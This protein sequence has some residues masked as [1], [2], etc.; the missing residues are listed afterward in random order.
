L[1]KI[2]FTTN[3]WPKKAEQTMTL[4]ALP[5]RKRLGTTNSLATVFG[6]TRI[7][8]DSMRLSRCLKI[9][10]R[11]TRRSPSIWGRT[12]MLTV[13]SLRRHDTLKRRKDES[14]LDCRDRLKPNGGMRRRKKKKWTKNMKTRKV[15][16]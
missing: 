4:Q 1:R 13:S 2:E 11:A 10:S 15:T 3:L 16:Y 6:P 8:K 7:T 9:N 12:L 5:P 14:G